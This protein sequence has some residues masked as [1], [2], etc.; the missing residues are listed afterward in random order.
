MTDFKRDR[1]GRPLINV[2]G[3]ETP[4]TRISSYAQILEDQT[5]LNRWKLRTV[6]SGVAQ[7]PDL[8]NLAT[9]NINNDRKLDDLAQQFLDAGGASRAANTGTAIH[10][11]LA[12]LDTGAI[13]LDNVP[14]QFMPY[15]KAWQTCLHQFGLE[16]IPELVEIPLVNDKYLA[17]GS[18]DNF[19]MR[20]SDGK[21]I[22]VDKKTGKTLMPRPL[23]YMAQLALYATSMQYDIA[24]GE[25]IA[26][27][28][29]DLEVGYIAHIPA[30]GDTCTFYE[31]DLQA[32]L[33]L[34]DLA[35]E[36]RNA[37]KSTPTLTVVAPPEPA[38][39]DLTLLKNRVQSL[40]SAGHAKFL[41]ERWPADTPTL[42]HQGHTAAQL[43]A[44]ARLVEQA[45]AEYS[46]PF[47]EEAKPVATAPAKPA[48]V[49]IA[50][51]VVEEGPMVDTATVSAMRNHVKAQPE[52][53]QQRLAAWA[54]E[55]SK[56]G[57][58]ISIS[59]KPSKRRFE[60]A[61]LMLTLAGTQQPEETLN[62]YVGIT[63]TVGAT[64]AT[65]TIQQIEDLHNQLQEA[66]YG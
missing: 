55:A 56:S 17:A 41:A 61:R 36:I 42:K 13:Q 4:Y 46:M 57:N 51:I 50:K 29:V 23:A 27:P 49:K 15:A 19:L 5:G 65:L 47:L 26:L 62:N 45:E 20:T 60:L 16:V 11:M 14:D 39:I 28:E 10:E 12:Q 18:S 34:C 22:T 30:I 35:M 9:A 38:K 54:K 32:A 48:P 43:A 1:Y 8:V 53:V 3:K 52:H 21:L 64:L 24:S 6:V 33:K 44:I 37:Q 40:V 31:V 59:A 58:S 2:D 63:S 7:R 66:K 25:R